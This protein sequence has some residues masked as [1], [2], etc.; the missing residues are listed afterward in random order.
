M[1]N[2]ILKITEIDKFK[3]TISETNK[4]YY[5]SNYNTWNYKT[6]ELYKKIINEA[7]LSIKLLEEIKKINQNHF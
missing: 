5:P 4:F 1:F 2:P 3:K 6:E 7:E